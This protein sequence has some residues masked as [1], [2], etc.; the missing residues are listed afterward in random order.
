MQRQADGPGAM[1]SILIKGGLPAAGAFLSKLKVNA[2]YRWLII[3]FMMKFCWAVHS[4]VFAL[5]V[6]LGAV[7]SL[8]CSPAIMTH[9]AV[10]KADREKVGITDGLVRLSLGEQICFTFTISFH[11]IFSD[12]LLP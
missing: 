8:A 9:T 5:A 11:P 7:E 12:R 2:T 4:Q 6:S 1:V 3:I 10:A